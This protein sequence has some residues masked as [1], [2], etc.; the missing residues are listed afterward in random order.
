MEKVKVAFLFPGQ[1]AQSVGMGL[2]LYEN[3]LKAKEV[4]ETA[5]KVL[6]YDI[7]KLCFE[8]PEEELKKTIHTQPALTA[9]SIAAFEAFM[10]KN[11]NI[12]L[13]YTAG[14]SL[15]EYSA[16]YASQ[17]LSMEDTFKAIQ[18]RA[19]CMNEAAVNNSGKMAAILGMEANKINE[20]LKNVKSGI[21]QVANYNTPEQTVITG[22]EKAIE[23]ACE[24]LKEAGAKKVI[25][26]NVSGAFHSS[27]MDSASNEFK[28][29]VDSLK[30]QDAKIP[31]ITNVDALETTNAVDFK[32]KM[33]SQI[34][35]SVKWVDSVNKMID[36]G[37][38]TFIELGAGKVLSGLVKKINK[39]VKVFNIQDMDSLNKTCES[40][41]L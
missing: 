10:E 31:V 24:L 17:V 2:D 23:E 11:P 27:L 5:N 18:K 39:E 20:V 34:N 29:F 36:S 21:A 3:S 40:L 6:G 22:E 16:M 37:I 33:P 30:I 19:Q 41:N 14:H 4:F 28:T 15:G 25:M 13:C 9:V 1:G 32:A 38:D 12:E 35:S 7:A 8:G 26:L